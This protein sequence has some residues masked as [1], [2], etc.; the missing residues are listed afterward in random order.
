ME[1]ITKELEEELAK[2]PLYSN[3]NKPLIEQEIIVKYFN[4]YGVGTW[5]ITEAEKQENG[6][7]LFY[8]LA[9]LIE[10]EAGYT[11]LKQLEEIRDNKELMSIERDLYLKDKTTIGEYLEANDI[12]TYKEY[13]ELADNMKKEQEA[14]ED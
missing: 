4:P 8:G 2:H 13:K 7:Y 12:E 5:L 1:L 11:T 3:E 10:W 9:H 6:D 14:E